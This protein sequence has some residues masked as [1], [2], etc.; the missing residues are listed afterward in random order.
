MNKYTILAGK[1][2]LAIGAM[3]VW[4]VPSIPAQVAILGAYVALFIFLQYRTLQSK[5]T[6]IGESVKQR[7]VI[8]EHIGGRIWDIPVKFTC[9]HCKYVKVMDF[10]LETRG[11][12]C[13][14]CQNPN[15]LIL[16]FTVIPESK[17][18]SEM[19]NE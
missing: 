15:K 19:T 3:L 13:E 2:F 17:N 7:E 18:S 4:L 11:F 10:S 14:R 6:L 5:R 1:I 16:Q 8:V 12:T 9:M